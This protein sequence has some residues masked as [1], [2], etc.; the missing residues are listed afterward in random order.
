MLNIFKTYFKNLQ[1]D[2]L[3]DAPGLLNI[4]LRK[5]MEI[6]IHSY[7]DPFKV[8][9]WKFHLGHPDE[10]TGLLIILE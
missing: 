7:P 2:T 6:S 8:V 1:G 9:D 10:E 5:G 4:N 3:G